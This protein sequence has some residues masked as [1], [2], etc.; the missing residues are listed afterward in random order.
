MPNAL[1]RTTEGAS[2]TGR[3]GEQRDEAGLAQAFCPS[4]DE[5]NVGIEQNPA[6]G[7][8]TSI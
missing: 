3:A 8:C 2:Q 6:Y 1:V 7:S 5:I 4:K